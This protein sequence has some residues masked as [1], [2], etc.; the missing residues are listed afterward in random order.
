MAPPL[1]PAA[2]KGFQNGS[3]YDQYRPSYPAEAVDSLLTHLQVS[4]LKGARVVDL[5]AGTGIF[6]KLLADRDEAF[7]ITAVE[8]HADM[9]AELSKKKL[10]G[11]RVL[12]GGASSMKGV[13]SQ[14][15]DA[16]VAAQVCLV[17]QTSQS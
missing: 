12:D 16:V 3:R 6:T 2:A 14:S 9:R 15:V 7:D 5:G 4:G 13:E 11:V 8:P 1:P 10:K 17:V